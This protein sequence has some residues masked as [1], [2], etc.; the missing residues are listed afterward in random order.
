MLLISVNPAT[1]AYQ[2]KSKNNFSKYRANNNTSVS[3]KLF[4]SSSQRT[5]GNID[6]NQ[7]KRLSNI[8]RKRKKI[9][10]S[11]INI[12]S[13]RNKLQEFEC[14]QVDFVAISET[15]LDSSFPTAQFNLPGF[16]TPYRKDITTR[17]GE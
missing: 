6:K 2:N 10:L 15:K 3:S 16:R 5:T 14:M 11:H 13:V 9:C 7:L 12:S 4:P 1:S 17:S 8:Y